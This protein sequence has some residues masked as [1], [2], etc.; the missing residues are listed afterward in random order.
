M[1]TGECNDLANL[2]DSVM[3]I[4]RWRCP[5]KACRKKKSIRHGSWFSHHHLTLE[6][7]LTITFLWSENLEPHIITSWAHVNAHTT[8]DWCN[9][10]C[11][12]RYYSTPLHYA[13][14]CKCR[15]VASTLT[16]SVSHYRRPRYYC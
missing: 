4:I 2:C 10:L 9:Y 14:I 15:H 6:Q 16:G 5:K 1:D 8:V 13:S 7:V 11:K 12:V 3:C